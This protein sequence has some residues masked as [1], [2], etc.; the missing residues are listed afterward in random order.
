M[1]ERLTNGLR[2]IIQGPSVAASVDGAWYCVDCCLERGYR[3]PFAG[4]VHERVGVCDAC[5]KRGVVF[6]IDDLVPPGEDA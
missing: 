3:W 5:A 4:H 1:L 6:D 2:R